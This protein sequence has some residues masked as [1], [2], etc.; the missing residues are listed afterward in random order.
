MKKHFPVW[1]TLCILALV[2]GGLLILANLLM[3]SDTETAQKAADKAA[4]L[5][6]M[7]GA[8]AFSELKLEKGAELDHCYTAVSNNK[9]MGYVGVV[10]VTGYN[11]PIEVMVGVDLSGKITAV[12]VGGAGFSETPGLGAKTVEKAFTGQFAGLTDDA[13]LKQNVQAVTGATISSGAVTAGVNKAAGYIRLTVL[14]IGAQPEGPE[15]KVF[16]GLLPGATT[17]KEE[18]APAGIDAVWSSDAGAVVYASER[19]YDDLIQVQVG[20]YN[21]GTIANVKINEQGFKE[22][23]GVGAHVKEKDFL[24]QFTGLS[25]EVKAGANA[26]TLSGATISS[27][28]VVKAVDK[29]LQAAKPFL[30]SA[31]P[32]PSGTA[33]A[34]STAPAGS[35]APAESTPPPE[36]KLLPGATNVKQVT[37]LPQGAEALWT[38]DQGVIVQT[39]AKG[40]NDLIHVKVGVLKDGT[41][42]GIE[43]LKDNFQETEGIGTLVLENSFQSQFTGKSGT[44]TIGK[45]ID[46]VSGATISSTGVVKAVNKALGIAKGLQG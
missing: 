44:M 3:S 4:F 34:E 31:N 46:A 25:G 28:A 11:G 16:G 23:E 14:G 24:K 15:D 42:G 5:R 21:D 22:T 33:P 40:R 36:N 13:K 1:L 19:G 18:T 30:N 9:A 12:N 38:A 20:V 26:D 2:A 8:A 37:V 7:P 29:A 39:S 43:I 10:T 32:K 6:V 17:K 45:N 27:T 35:T 41:I